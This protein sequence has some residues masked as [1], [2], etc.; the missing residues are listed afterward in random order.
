MKK[1]TI[2]GNNGEIEFQKI[3]EEK[4][5]DKIG[6]FVNF[7]LNMLLRIQLHKNLYVFVVQ[8][9]K[10]KYLGYMYYKPNNS[11]NQSRF[12]MFSI[13]GKKR[14]NDV[15]CVLWRRRILITWKD[16]MRQ[17]KNQGLKKNLMKV[18]NKKL[19]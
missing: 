9:R 12:D 2:N 7:D 5:S 10:C 16:L 13:E 1:K 14:S 19:Y 3:C 15:E 4:K 8:G 6:N 11:R 18:I 17:R